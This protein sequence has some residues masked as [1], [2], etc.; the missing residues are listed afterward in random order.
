MRTYGSDYEVN[1]ATMEITIKMT[2]PTEQFS[3]Y[4]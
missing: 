4:K 1:Q 3:I 2:R